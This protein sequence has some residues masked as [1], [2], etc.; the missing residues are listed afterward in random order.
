M[1]HVDGLV[2]ERHNSIANALELHLSC[3]NPSMLF[4]KTKWSFMV[5]LMVGTK[6]EQDLTTPRHTGD[7]IMM[8]WETSR[9]S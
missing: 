2:Q 4:L 8:P 7:K 3:T 9:V 6:I 5:S 1:N